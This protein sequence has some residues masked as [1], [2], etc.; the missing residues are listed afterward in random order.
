MK[1]ATFKPVF[2][3]DKEIEVPE[4][5]ADLDTLCLFA[6]SFNGYEYAGGLVELAGNE[7]SLWDKTINKMNAGNK[8]EVSIEDLRACMFWEQRGARY[9]SQLESDSAYDIET[10]KWFLQ[11]IRAK[12]NI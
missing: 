2:N 9:H 4:M 1:I 12:L 3:E 5:D 8:D 11:E 10:F 6:L 7:Q